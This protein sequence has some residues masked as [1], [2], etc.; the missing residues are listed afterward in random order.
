MAPP[1]AITK[2][3]TQGQAA[4]GAGLAKYYTVTYTAPSTGVPS[5][6]L[7]IQLVAG[8][9]NEGV[10]LA[11]FDDVTLSASPIPEPG[12]LA[13]LAVGGVIVLKRRRR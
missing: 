4:P 12:M 8:G 3:G 9:P 7:L 13:L 11:T 1:L 2:I 10:L 5:G 6:N